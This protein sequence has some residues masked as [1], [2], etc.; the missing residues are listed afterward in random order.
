MHLCLCVLVHASC[1]FYMEFVIVVVGSMFAR[2]LM[3][4]GLGGEVWWALRRCYGNA[5]CARKEHNR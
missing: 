5:S 4:Q 3:E 1:V 2:G